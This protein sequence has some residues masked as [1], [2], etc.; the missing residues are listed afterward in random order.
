MDIFHCYL[1]V[2]SPQLKLNESTTNDRITMKMFHRSHIVAHI[3]RR[4]KQAH[5]ND[6]KTMENLHRSLHAS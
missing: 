4:A 1:I 5:R 6:A 3:T 2:K